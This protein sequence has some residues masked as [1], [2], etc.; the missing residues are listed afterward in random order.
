MLDGKR[1]ARAVGF[2]CCL[3][4]VGCGGL[5]GSAFTGRGALDSS[6]ALRPIPRAAPDL[7][8][9]AEVLAASFQQSGEVPVVPLP[10]IPMGGDS[11]PPAPPKPAP[12]PNPTPP[13]EKPPPA[14]DTAA[15]PANGNAVRRLH[16]QAAA[17]TATMDSYIV[18]L[19]RREQVN[20][21]D[22]P[23]EVLLFKFRKQPWSVYFKWLGTEGQGREVLYVQGQH[24]NKIH[25][26]LAAGDVPLM[27]GGKR[28]S[29]AVDSPLVQS[30]S[31][32]P[33]TEAGL[34][35]SVERLGVRL[36]ALDR[37]DKKRGTLTYLGPQNRPDFPRP[38][39][40][41]EHAIPAGAEKALPRGGNR[42]YGFDPDSQLP[43]LVITRDDRGAEVEYYRYDRL[44][45]PVLLDA[46]DF[47]PD[48]LWKKSER[49]AR[50]S[51]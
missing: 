14:A 44:Q 27:A 47:D 49:P 42:L 45:F 20:G 9:P 12:P 15:T 39:E 31:R 48:K 21:K 2:W 23:E 7:R 18:R 8:I 41:V 17:R 16:Q 37:G 51:P 46:D 33:I 32:H 13:L 11:R 30:A 24:E 40:M 35:A 5:A 34:A 43:V 25:T 1:A 3:A 50:N 22:N 36:D 6:P 28:M 38:L 26:L 10:P 29:F 4:V 19:T